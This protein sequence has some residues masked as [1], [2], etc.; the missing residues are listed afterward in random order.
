MTSKVEPLEVPE[1]NVPSSSP[2]SSTQDQDGQILE[3]V[4]AVHS[5]ASGKRP[6]PSLSATISLNRL[7]PNLADFNPQEIHGRKDFRSFIN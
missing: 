6:I 4:I 2:V 3:E 7:N 5:S 1:L